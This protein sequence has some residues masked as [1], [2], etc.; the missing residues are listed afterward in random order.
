MCKV[1][2]QPLSKSGSSQPSTMMSC[3]LTVTAVTLNSVALVAILR[4]AFFP[5]FTVHVAV[6]PP[7]FVVAVI[8]AEPSVTPAAALTVPFWSTVTTLS[9][10]DAHVT[11]LFVAFKGA[12]VA[13]SVKLSPVSIVCVVL[14]RL[15]PV[16]CS[17][18]SSLPY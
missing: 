3:P 9:L 10:S 6:K 1:A 5:T 8:T 14:L 2:C 15:T 12:T 18:L 11:P 13:V 7:S 16:T 4:I 17:G